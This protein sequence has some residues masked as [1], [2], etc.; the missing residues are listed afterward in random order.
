[1]GMC[2]FGVQFWLRSE[3]V[4]G[5]I[6]TGFFDGVVAP[7][8]GE[9]VAVGSTSFYSW[10]SYVLGNE[11]VTLGAHWAFH[12]ANSLPFLKFGSLF[13]PDYGARLLDIYRSLAPWGALSNLA[14][15]VLGFG[16]AGVILLS[17]LSGVLIRYW[18]SLMV[19]YYSKGIQISVGGVYIGSVIS[20]T[21]L[22]YRSG[23]G[24]AFF[25]LIFITVL[26]FSL[27]WM[28]VLWQCLLDLFLARKNSNLEKDF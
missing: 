9:F 25:Y 26:Y 10:T 12:L 6:A 28:G 18:H 2:F 13:F 3:N 17:I 8:L 20:T 22:K 11:P 24:D 7:Q 5:N 27:V 1:M 14:D 19:K 15:S 16:V 23:L 21:I 4:D